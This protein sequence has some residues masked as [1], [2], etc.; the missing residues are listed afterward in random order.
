MRIIRQHVGH[1][2]V[3]TYESLQRKSPGIPSL[4]IPSLRIQ[5]P[6]N[7]VPAN[8]VPATSTPANPVP[9]SPVSANPLPANPGLANPVSGK[10]RPGEYRLPSP[11]PRLNR[12]QFLA[13]PVP[14]N[15]V[16]RQTRLALA[17]SFSRRRVPACFVCQGLPQG[18][19][20]CVGLVVAPCRCIH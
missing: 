3:T 20:S 11:V 5:F 1:H 7:P 6:A 12:I 13:K 14:E 10:C 15:P 17:R 4:R 8:P 9:A 18:F 2:S 19:A 16:S